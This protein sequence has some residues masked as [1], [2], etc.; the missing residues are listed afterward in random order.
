VVRSAVNTPAQTQQPVAQ[1]TAPPV[2]LNQPVRAADEFQPRPQPVKMVSI[3]TPT[4]NEPVTITSPDTNPDAQLVQDSANKPGALAPD[5]TVEHKPGASAPDS[6]AQQAQSTR[7][8]PIVARLN[9]EAQKLGETVVPLNNPQQQPVAMSKYKVEPGDSLSKIAT[10]V[11]GTSSKTVIAAIIEANPSLKAN[12]NLVI[13][14]RTYNMPAL[15]TNK[16]VALAPDANKPGAS[17]PDASS[18]AMQNP[19]VQL[20]SRTELNS[21]V[22]PGATYTVEE[23]DNLTRIAR[24]QCGTEDAVA[25]IKELNREALKGGDVIRPGMKLKLPAKSVAVNQ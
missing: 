21:K 10:K 6:F 2:T 11:Y 7:T 4:Q 3:D 24:E 1:V 8:D 25:A 19:V 12:P 22:E 17:A 5:L 14:G 15:T 23:G 16:P 20:A 9:A 13:E 18:R